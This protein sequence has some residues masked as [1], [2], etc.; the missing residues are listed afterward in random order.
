[1]ELPAPE[2]FIV[3][4]G[5]LKLAARGRL[6]VLRDLHNIVVIKIESR[7]GEVRLGFRRFLLDGNRPA[8]FIELHNAET[9]RV[10]DII[11]ENRC[12]FFSCDRLPHQSAEI[13]SV[14][15]IVSE[16]KRDGVSADELFPDQECLRQT[17]RRRLNLI[18]EADAEA[19]A[20]PEQADES[21]LILR[22]RD[23]ENLV[24]ACQHQNRERIVD[25]RLVINREQLFRHSLC[26]RVQSGS[27]ASCQYN[28]FHFAPPV[29]SRS[30][31]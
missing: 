31:L 5:D 20:V 24:D 27:R 26:D 29:P 1:M 19:G 23:D 21:R 28:A 7:H 8:V 9:F 4:A 17:V 25:H 10:A 15:N 3:H 13:G 12:T 6:D 11:S 16:N 14:E 18:G 30:R 2:I 22:R